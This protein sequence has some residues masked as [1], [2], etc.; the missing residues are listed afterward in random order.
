MSK[1]V[2]S[3]IV[4]MLA[5]LWCFAQINSEMLEDIRTTPD[6]FDKSRISYYINSER[7]NPYDFEG[8]YQ[9][10]LLNMENGLYE[11]AIAYFRKLI[12]PKPD[13]VG[14]VEEFPEPYFYIGLCKALMMEYDSAMY[15]YNEAIN[16]KPTYAAAYNERG[17]IHLFDGNFDEALSDFERAN[18]YDAQNANPMYNIGYTYFLMGDY[19]SA[20]KHIK[21]ASRKFPDFYLNQ[22]LLGVIYM[23]E[24]K[25]QKAI[26]SFSKSIEINP[27]NPWAYFNR[28]LLKVGKGIT[29]FNMS[30]MFS[31]KEDM[32]LVT[33]IDSTFVE[34]YY[35]KFFLAMIFDEPRSMLENQFLALKYS[36]IR[37]NYRASASPQDLE[38]YYLLD[39]LLN[40][41]SLTYKE[42]ELGTDYFTASLI[43]LDDYIQ[44]IVKYSRQQPK[45]FFMKR[46]IAYHYLNT[47]DTDQKEAAVFSVLMM[48]STLVHL[49][50]VLADVYVEQG[51]H[52]RGISLF[53]QLLAADSLNGYLNYKV[54]NA[55]FEIDDNEA[56]IRNYTRAVEIFPRYVNAYIQRAKVYYLEDQFDE[57]LKDVSTAIFID[58]ENTYAWY[59]SGKI[60]NTI[61]QP[62]SALHMLNVAIEMAPYDRDICMETADSYLALNR[63]EMVDEVFE[64]Y[65][66]ECG[67][68]IHSYL[69]A[70][71][72][73]LYETDFTDKAEEYFNRAMK[74]DPENAAA[75]NAMGDFYSSSKKQDYQKAIEYYD[76]AMWYWAAYYSPA[77][78]AGW[79]YYKLEDFD[80]AIEYLDLAMTIDSTMAYPSLLKGFIYQKMEDNETALRYFLQAAEINDEYASAWGNAG[81][82]CYLLGDYEKCIE[83]SEKAI[84]LDDEAYYA[85]ANIAL[86]HLRLG[87]MDLALEEYEKYHEKVSDLEDYDNSGAIKDLEDLIDEDIMVAEA[88]NILETFFAEEE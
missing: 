29:Y 30:H 63:P 49:K 24:N 52:E 81:W 71:R 58:P 53:E 27:Y 83:Y 22:L 48:D 13:I 88:Q 82:T 6:P 51:Q 79:C 34:A 7:L 4:L 84:A 86:T 26:K 54:G 40:N 8:Q 5:S 59:F 17:S 21:K 57:A 11:E 61:G 37:D 33:Q 31:A 80:T 3:L 85:M 76:Q 14:S 9:R 64:D 70:G 44:S 12:I 75:N 32:D 55:Y 78:N 45:S 16:I 20:R 1:T 41:S 46:L 25:P 10:G 66:D 42:K 72:Y 56:A 77:K 74:I 87:E 62:D 18:L 39:N 38:K 73:Y 65:I 69:F 36:F 67:K 15:F 60:Y 35:V 28:G 50:S 2:C 19:K 23:N 68:T 47:N 43:E